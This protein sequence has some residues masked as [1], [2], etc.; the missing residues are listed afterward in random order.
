MNTTTA[1][2]TGSVR[3]INLDSLLDGDGFYREPE[4]WTPELAGQLARQDGLAELT[5]E[6][7]Q[8][9]Q[10]L[11]EHYGRFGA[12]PPAFAHICARMHRDTHCVERLFQSEREAW[13]IAGL[14]NPGEEAKAYL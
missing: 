6:H 8:V 10:A 1:S 12:A 4:A 5:A 9:I 2:S 3:D 7:W 13:R 14:P 11:R